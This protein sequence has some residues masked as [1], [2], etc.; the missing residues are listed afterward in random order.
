MSNRIYRIVTQ[1][2]EDKGCKSFIDLVDVPMGLALLSMTIDD[3]KDH[4]PD[5][6]FEQIIEDITH[7]P[8]VHQQMSKLPTCDT[9]QPAYHFEQGYE[10]LPKWFWEL[11]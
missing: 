4:V 7:D 11:Q 2:M 1:E 9:S 3:L 8:R 5:D 10:E 6:Q